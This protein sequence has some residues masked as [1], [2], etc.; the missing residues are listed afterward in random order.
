MPVSVC[1]ELPTGR[2][3]TVP[4]RARG[5]GLPWDMRER[6]RGTRLAAPERKAVA[7][8]EGRL[9]WQVRLGFLGKV[10][11]KTI[12]IRNSLLRHE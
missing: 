12:I 1:L 2:Q 8:K 9:K 3:Q 6:S 7:D 5:A 11:L 4:P 10:Y